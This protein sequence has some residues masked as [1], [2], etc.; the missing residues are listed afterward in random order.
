M[1]DSLR[2]PLHLCSGARGFSLS[3][4]MKFEVEKMEK[5][6]SQKRINSR[7]SSLFQTPQANRWRNAAIYY[8]DCCPAVTVWWEVSLALL[9]ELV[10]IV[11]VVVEPALHQC[12]LTAIALWRK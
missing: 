2:P 7:F 12:R 3:V 4:M 9:L 8:L 5:N 1:H 6:F 10:V 11:L